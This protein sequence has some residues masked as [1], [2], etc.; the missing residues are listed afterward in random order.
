MLTGATVTVAVRGP[1]HAHVVVTDWKV[2]VGGLGGVT[3]GVSISITGGLPGIKGRGVQEAMGVEHLLSWGTGLM[4]LTQ[5]F[6]LTFRVRILLNVS[7]RCTERI[8]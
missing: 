3:R 8:F 1:F 5:L 4:P 2:G 6:T 7:T